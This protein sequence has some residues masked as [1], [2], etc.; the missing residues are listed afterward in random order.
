MP[1]G[2][3]AG[4]GIWLL[5]AAAAAGVMVSSVTSDIVFV[6]VVV[7]VVVTKSPAG[8]GAAVESCCAK[9]AWCNSKLMSSCRPAGKYTWVMTCYHAVQREAADSQTT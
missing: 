9:Q 6:V 1:A 3:D 8:T 5:A 2:R 4:W 7:T